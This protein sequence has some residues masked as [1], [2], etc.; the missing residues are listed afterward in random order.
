MHPRT[1]SIAW[2]GQQFQFQW[3]QHKEP[4]ENSL[5]W[6]VSRRGE[7]IGTMACP[8]GVTTAEF[9]VRCIHWLADLLS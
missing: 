1:R 4:T 9:D 2:R 7:F 3:L 5:Q 6:A 8:T